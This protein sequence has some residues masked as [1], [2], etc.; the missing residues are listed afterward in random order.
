MVTARRGGQDDIAGDDP[1]LQEGGD[2]GPTKKSGGGR[3]VVYSQLSRTARSC[4]CVCVC[5]FENGIYRSIGVGS[6]FPTHNY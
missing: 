6:G 3:G 4:V 5:V 2:W 1:V